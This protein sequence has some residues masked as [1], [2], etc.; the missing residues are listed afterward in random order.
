MRNWLEVIER[1]RGVVEEDAPDRSSNT[2]PVEEISD[3]PLYFVLYGLQGQPVGR[4]PVEIPLQPNGNRIMVLPSIGTSH[5]TLSRSAC[6][7]A[8]TFPSRLFFSGL[9]I[10]FPLEF[11]LAR[12]F[13]QLTPQNRQDFVDLSRAAHV[14]VFDHQVRSSLPS[15]PATREGV[16]Q[17]CASAKRVTP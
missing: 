7:S 14:K 16:Q 12:C 10:C 4:P 6:H 3:E 2:D 9:A 15:P 17:R 13:W 11:T 8:T 1:E 5:A